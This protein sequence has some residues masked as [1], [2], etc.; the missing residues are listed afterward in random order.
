M[1]IFDSTPSCRIHFTHHP[2][3]SICCWIYLFPPV[4]K[5]V[6]FK[7]VTF[8]LNLTTKLDYTLSSRFR[9]WKCTYSLN[10]RFLG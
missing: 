8:L 10:H 6:S 2:L 9:A 7:I 3:A 1:L 5:C 4:S